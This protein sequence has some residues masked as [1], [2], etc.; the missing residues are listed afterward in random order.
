MGRGQNVV[1]PVL[2]GLFMWGI[3]LTGQGAYDGALA[4]LEEGL[5]LAERAGDEN[6]TPRYLNSLGW[7]YRECGDLPRAL[8]LHRRI[9]EGARQR[10]SDDALANARLNL[11]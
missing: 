3:N 9:I 7:L 6:Y 10:R 5:A 4:L 2:E 1:L 8:A 11:A